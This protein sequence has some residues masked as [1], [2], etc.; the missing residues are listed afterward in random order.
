M[1]RSNSLLFCIHDDNANVWYWIK[2]KNRL[3]LQKKTHGSVAVVP[4]MFQYLFARLASK[5]GKTDI[6]DTLVKKSSSRLVAY[7]HFCFVHPLSHEFS[8]LIHLIIYLKNG[9]GSTI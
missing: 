3:Y 9:K 2:Q 1:T 7:P 8:N 5:N 4:L 6:G